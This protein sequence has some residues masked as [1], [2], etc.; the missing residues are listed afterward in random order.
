VLS[1]FYVD[2]ILTALWLQQKKALDF[3]DVVRVT[4]RFS[5]ELEHSDENLCEM[6]RMLEEL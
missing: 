6:D 4:Y 2:E 3:C 1:V 5:R